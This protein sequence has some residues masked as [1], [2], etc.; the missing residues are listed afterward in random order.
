M[1]QIDTGNLLTVYTHKKIQD[2]RNDLRSNWY[3]RSK[4]K[5]YNK[6]KKKKKNKIKK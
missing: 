4:R 5:E 1:N 2:K 6:N 3:K